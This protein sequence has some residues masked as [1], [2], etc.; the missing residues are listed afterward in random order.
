[1]YLPVPTQPDCARAWREAVRLVDAKP[2]HEAY[3]VL[4]DISD[5]IAGASTAHP[6]V[7]AVDA[8]LAARAK[9]VETVANTIFPASFYYRYGAP[10]FFDV[11]QKKVL[12]KVRGSQ[13][14]SGYYFER[15]ISHPAISG[16]PRNQLWDMIERMKK[17]TSLNKFEILLFD[18]ERDVDNSNYGRQCLSFLSFKVIPERPRALTLTAQYRNHYY[19]EKLLGNLI[20]L[21]RLMAFVG[22]ETGLSVG[23]L[24]VLSTHATIDQPKGMLRADLAALLDTFDRA[25]ANQVV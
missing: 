13:R 14:W 23:P 11:F 25:T 21:G 4:I 5:P 9:P 22:R 15:M 6:G 2:G 16:A 12:P 10:E 19:I 24:T 17:S 8:V 3:N 1:M 7:A 18:P 20:G